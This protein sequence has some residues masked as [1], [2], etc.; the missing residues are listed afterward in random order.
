MA[1]PCEALVDLVHLALEG[2]CLQLV[3]QEAAATEA[4]RMGCRG[5]RRDQVV[6]EDV[7]GLVGVGLGWVL[8]F[9][10]AVGLGIGVRRSCYGMLG[11]VVRHVSGGNCPDPGL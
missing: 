1:E 7:L 4:K 6:E 3:R 2:R 9:G 5:A 11:G 8:E 10:F